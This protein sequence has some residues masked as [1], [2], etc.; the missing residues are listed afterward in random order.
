[1][2]K[3]SVII[4]NWNGKILLQDCLRSLARQS[5]KDFEI[6]VVDNGS[7]D[8]SIEFLQSKYPYVKIIKFGENLGF[9]KAVN[10]GIKTSKSKYILLLN[11]DTKVNR[12]CLKLLVDMLERRRD[13]CAVVPK[14]VWFFDS[15]IIDSA[16]DV[17]NTVGQA[18][19]RGWREKS[20]KWNIPEEVFLCTAG[21]SLYRKKAFSKIG[22][23]DES[24]FI[25]GEDVDWCLRAQLAGCKFWYEPKAIVYHYHKAT[26]G[27]H[28]PRFFEYLHFRNMALT[29]IKNFP[30]QL[31]L[32]RWRIITIPLVHFN[33]IL[34]MAFHGLWKE[35]LLADFWIITHL[36][37]ILKKRWRIQKTR[38]VNINYLD[39][40]M[41]P[42]KI[43]LWGLLK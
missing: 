11:N 26:T 10:K 24:F 37:Q 21:A 39:K 33:T 32:K 38:R 23:F 36:P 9:A 1:M 20:S 4:P 19:H 28:M 43:R 6:I 30:W 7:T 27:E 31:F 34:Y 13:I 42:K 40:W 2:I 12:H 15:S 25:Y 14:V 22:L 41:E 16:G 18:F 29:I 5:F 3:L 8:G 35:A 17:M